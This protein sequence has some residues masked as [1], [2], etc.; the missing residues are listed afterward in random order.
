MTDSLALLC[1]LIGLELVLGADNILVISV[2][3]GRL[4][5]THRNKARITG[6]AVAMLAR[7]LMLFLLLRLS[8]LTEN[9]I[10]LC[11]TL[12]SMTIIMV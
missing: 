11:Q 9:I 1:L 5:E 6:L 3:V 10:F 12:I 7:I 4:P 8:R 2:F